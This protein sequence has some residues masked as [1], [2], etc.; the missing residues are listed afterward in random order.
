MIT[1]LIQSSRWGEILHHFKVILFLEKPESHP[2]FM[3]CNTETN[4]QLI[5]WIAQWLIDSPYSHYECHVP[6]IGVKCTFFNLSIMTQCWPGSNPASSR[7][8]IIYANSTVEK[9]IS[10]LNIIEEGCEIGD[11]QAFKLKCT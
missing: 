5:N 4:R 6:D 7:H 9:M 3:E 11:I 1:L 10:Y 2:F 8:A